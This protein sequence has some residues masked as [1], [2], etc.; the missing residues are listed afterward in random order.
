MLR[1]QMLQWLLICKQVALVRVFTVGSLPAP[2]VRLV[3]PSPLGLSSFSSL[4][5]P[6]VGE[7]P[8]LC[9]PSCCQFLPVFPYLVLV[10]NE[11]DT[12]YLQECKWQLPQLTPSCMQTESCLHVSFGEILLGFLRGQGEDC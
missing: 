1:S 6:W 8:P 9:F 5:P 3:W 4:R 2:S 7:D 11:S 12:A 10:V